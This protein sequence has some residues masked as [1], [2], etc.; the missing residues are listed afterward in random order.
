MSRQ[1]HS[2]HTA[3]HETRHGINACRK[4]LRRTRATRRIEDCQ[5]LLAQEANREFAAL[6]S[7]IDRRAPGR[8][9]FD[10]REEADAA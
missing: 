10:K 4:R 6:A 8:A 5:A 9:R 2:L 7:E 1:N 3:H